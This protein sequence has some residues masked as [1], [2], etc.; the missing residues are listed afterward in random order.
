MLEEYAKILRDYYNCYMGQ[1][2]SESEVSYIGW[3][4]SN[5]IFEQGTKAN[6]EHIPVFCLDDIN[7]DGISELVISIDTSEGY[8]GL[9]IYGYNQNEKKVCWIVCDD[10]RGWCTLLED[11]KIYISSIEG[12]Y[13]DGSEYTDSCYELDENGVKVLI[14]EKREIFNNLEDMPIDYEMPN[15]ETIEIGADESVYYKVENGTYIKISEEEYNKYDVTFGTKEA[16]LPY[17]QLTLEE[18][19]NLKQLQSSH[20][21]SEEQMYEDTTALVEVDSNASDFVIRNGALEEYIGNDTKVVIPDGVQVIKKDAF[22]EYYQLKEVTIPKSVK[23]IEYNAF[24]VCGLEKIVIP[25]SVES[26][27]QGAFCECPLKEIVLSKGLKRIESSAFFGCNIKEIVIPEG[28]ESIGDWA[29]AYCFYLK[30]AV[31]P[32]SVV[33]IGEDIFADSPEDFVIYGKENSHIHRY[34]KEHNISFVAL[35]D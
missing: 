7:K 3:T 9:D 30:K 31:V 1:D 13:R 14:A 28:V 19:E 33:S 4:Y 12:G 17:K 34:A 24:A 11:G 18:I 26:I 23:Y 8:G 15:G 32:E 35:T 27:G 10:Y 20:S 29:F 25:E 16:E 6:P 21:E 2:T 5:N 22:C